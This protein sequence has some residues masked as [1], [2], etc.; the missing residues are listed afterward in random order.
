MRTFRV[1][2]HDGHALGGRD[3]IARAGQVVGQG[4]LGRGEVEALGER[5]RVDT[6][7]VATAHGG[8][9]L[10]VKPE[11]DC[12]GAWGWEGRPRG[13]YAPI[14]PPRREFGNA[15]GGDS[16]LWPPWLG[17]DRRCFGNGRRI[18]ATV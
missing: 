8:F 9:S 6:N 18:R 7:S 14:P 11:S 10:W 15:F 1:A 3:I 12:V 5:F 2:H 16:G 13:D 4:Q 17:Y